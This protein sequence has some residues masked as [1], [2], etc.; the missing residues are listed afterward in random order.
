MTMM[1]QEYTVLT[2]TNTDLGCSY[3]YPSRSLTYNFQFCIDLQ[4]LA[5][6]LSNKL[7]VIISICIFIFFHSEYA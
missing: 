4:K 5:E 6:T 3:R 2:N 1:Y 7:D